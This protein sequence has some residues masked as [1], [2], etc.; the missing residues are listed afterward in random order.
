[1]PWVKVVGIHIINAIRE[2]KVPYDGMVHNDSTWVPEWVKNA[3]ML[4]NKSDGYAGLTLA[5][6]LRKMTPGNDSR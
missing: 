4:Y 6:F 5:E 1:M 3:V 2:S